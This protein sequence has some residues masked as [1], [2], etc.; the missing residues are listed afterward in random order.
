MRGW[1][2]R[3]ALA[4]VA[5]AVPLHSTPSGSIAAP[6]C[7]PAP[8]T[9]GA[10]A[11]TWRG[12]VYIVSTDGTHTCRLTGD[13]GATNA[14]LPRS[15]RCGEPGSPR[16]VWHSR[17]SGAVMAAEWVRDR[18]SD[19]SER[20]VGARHRHYAHRLEGPDS[21]PD[22]AVPG[23]AQRSKQTADRVPRSAC[24]CHLLERTRL[25]ADVR[26]RRAHL[27]RLDSADAPAARGER[28]TSDHRDASEGTGIPRAGRTSGGRNAHARLSQWTLSAP[29]PTSRL[30]GR[31]HDHPPGPAHSDSIATALRGF[32]IG[33]DDR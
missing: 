23:L 10:M 22:R 27:G 9:R 13:A 8:G 25:R 12:A 21:D 11:A 33:L 15:S 1:Q 19:R 2:T 7:R 20:L 6:S 29:G 16:D 28:G 17:G 30:L 5:V 4:A 32:P 31:R 14:Q 26:R 3:L 24:H 18:R